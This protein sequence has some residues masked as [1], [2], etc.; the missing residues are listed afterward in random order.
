MPKRIFIKY[1]N[2]KGYDPTIETQ[3][4]QNPQEHLV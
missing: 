3:K 1:N 4:L 2:T